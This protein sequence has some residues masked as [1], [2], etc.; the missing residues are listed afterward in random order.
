MKK[1]AIAAAFS[2]AATG[3]FAGSMEEPMMEAPVIVEEVEESS[4]SNGI[5]VPLILV[6]LVA[7][8]VAAD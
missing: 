4:T 7:A 8:A 5:I 6:A 2:V 1:I 3:A